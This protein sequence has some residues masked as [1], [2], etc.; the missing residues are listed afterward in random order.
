[1]LLCDMMVR[2]IDWWKA[3]GKVSLES[4]DVGVC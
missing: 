1:M 2:S 3:A 4:L